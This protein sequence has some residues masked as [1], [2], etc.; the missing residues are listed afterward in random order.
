MKGSS[1]S[2]GAP[3]LLLAW[4]SF[5]AWGGG[6]GSGRS[7]A[8]SWTEITRL[9]YEHLDTAL[10]PAWEGGPVDYPAWL[11]E[12]DGQPVEIVGFMAPYD[13]LDD[14]SRFMLMPS[15]VGCY[16]CAPPS[17]T[18]VL[19]V[20]QAG[21]GGKRR[22]IDPPI[23]VSGILRLYRPGSDH[24]AHRDQFVYAL[25]DA[26]CTIVTGD[27]V[28]RRAKAH[29]AG[30]PRIGRADEPPDP[31]MDPLQPHQ[32]F[33]PQLLVPAVS[34]LRSLPLRGEMRFTKTGPAALEVAIE[35]HVRDGL[36]EAGGQALDRALK[37]LG[38]LP[39]DLSW[40]RAVVAHRLP[41]S[42]GTVSA[43]GGE[44]SYHEDLPLSKPAGRLAMACLIY[45]A[46]LR[47]NHPDFFKPVPDAETWLVRRA[48]LEG[49]LFLLRNDYVRRNW[50]S[51]PDPLPSL[52]WSS[53]RADLPEGFNRWLE[54]PGQTGHAFLSR[55][56]N[57]E[58]EGFLDSLYTQPPAFFSYWW[59]P[60]WLTLKEP[61]TALIPPSIPGTIHSP[62]RLGSATLLAWLGE[63]KGDYEDETLAARMLQDRACWITSPESAEETFLWQ[64]E[65]A[66]ELDA[67]AFVEWF[68][69]SQP[70]LHGGW[71]SRST[72]PHSA[73]VELRQVRGVPSESQ[74][75]T[76]KR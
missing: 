55:N 8:A 74:L 25:D 42:I 51:A 67:R 14:L 66:D 12:L 5:L 54:L 37:A 68:T 7:N 19:L 57:W 64:T 75:T 62:C 53:P 45:E 43:D 40:D 52:A 56:R 61:S 11:D 2:L 22:F 10:M 33:Q 36:T 28:P 21:E 26:T 49:D 65:W 23:R 72:G 29:A 18:Q 9:T 4:V 17:F 20:Q 69:A 71:S 60:D 58:S 50:L 46:L 15:Y 35:N 6:S 47:Q 44:V 70:S 30:P 34:A 48:L 38:W 1:I 31:G 59:R 73:T 16:F 32:A 3:L 39:D 27:E 24:P 76:T 63:G 13:R 41:A